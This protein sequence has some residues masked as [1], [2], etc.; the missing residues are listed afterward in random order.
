MRASIG[1]LLALLVLLGLAAV[2]ARGQTGTL[3]GRVMDAESG[4]TIA[5]A[6]VR[7]LA[8][9]GGEVAGGLT[10]S[11]GQFELQVPAGSYQVEVTSL[12]FAS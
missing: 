2:P 1:R 9:G 8:P 10:D 3:S 4:E 6:V 7:V 5:N 11:D 12:G